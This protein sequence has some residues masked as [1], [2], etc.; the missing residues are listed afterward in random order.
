MPSRH[1]R[2]AALISQKIKLADANRYALSRWSYAGNW[3]MTG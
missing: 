3:V 2:A 1:G